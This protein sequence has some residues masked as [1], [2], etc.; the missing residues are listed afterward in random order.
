MPDPS[1]KI[2]LRT[3]SRNAHM[4]S[5]AGESFVALLMSAVAV[6]ML[7]FRCWPAICFGSRDLSH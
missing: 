5:T 1:C 3:G 2:K 4:K 7:P 6:G